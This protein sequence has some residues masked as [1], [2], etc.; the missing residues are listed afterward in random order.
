MLYFTVLISELNRFSL[1]PYDFYRA[2][3]RMS[4]VRLSVA[5]QVNCDHMLEFLDNNLTVK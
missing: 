1:V 3:L 2:M 5:A 4:S